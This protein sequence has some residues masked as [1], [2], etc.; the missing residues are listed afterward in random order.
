MK[1]LLLFLLATVLVCKESKISPL[2]FG[3]L[4]YMTPNNP[5]NFSESQRQSEAEK[6]FASD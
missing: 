5:E 3:N 1:S 6:V 4:A 2:N